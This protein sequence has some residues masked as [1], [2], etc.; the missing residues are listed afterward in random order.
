MLAVKA[1]A[2]QLWQFS[3]GQPF[4]QSRFAEDGT[5]VLM[6]AGFLLS[7]TP[8]LKA[9][10]QQAEAHETAWCGTLSTHDTHAFVFTRR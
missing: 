2:R 10:I 5:H 8:P 9:L 7:D 6:N 4:P 1:K 3:D